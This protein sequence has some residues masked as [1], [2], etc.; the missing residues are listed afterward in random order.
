MESIWRQTCGIRSRPGLDQNIETDA[1]VIG[2]GMAGILI[3]DALKTA[4]R[5]VVVLEA[6]RIAGGQTQNTTAKITAQHG[7][8]Y[9]KLIRSFGE[10]RAKQYAQANQEAVSAYRA[11]IGTRRIDCDFEARDAFLYGDDLP[12]L[13]AE[14]EAAARLGL[15][16]DL[17]GG[18]GLPF[19]CAGAVRFRDQAQFHPLKFLRAL[20]DGLTVYEH[21]PVKVVGGNILKAG[22]H[23]VRA[24]HVVFAC[25][26][27][28]VNFPGLY[29]ARMYQERSYVLALENAPLAD[30]MFLGAD[31]GGYSLRWWNGLLLFGG[32]SRRAGE[33][34]DGGRYDALRRKAV[35]LFPGCR[36]TARWS[37][38]DCIPADGVPY[39]GL[40]A[41]SR[42]NWYVATGF[43][44]WGMT[45][46]MVS[47]QIITDLICGRRNPYAAVFSPARFGGTAAGGVLS[48]VGHSVKGLSRLFLQVPAAAAEKLLPGHGGIVFLNGKKVGVYREPGGDIHMVDPR[49]PHLGC[50]VEWDPD[51]LSWD[52]P[53]HGSRF[54]YTGKLISGPA[55]T[56][57]RG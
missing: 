46:S 55:Q 1:A 43:Q 12:A 37:A 24:N 16:A 6:D 13:S 17:T 41:S 45:S 5:Q 23:T 35:E 34:S 38:Q 40:Y 31:G 26:Y 28:F 51:E 11:L 32:E 18:A 14:A 20:A 10:Q 8:I 7:M 3:A 39:I 19:P 30:G 33:N 47:A 25:H 27:P 52:C 22:G 21:T 48:E 42:P 53:C 50:Q 15:P 36:E 29:F 57:L 4:G 56:D 44:K 49:C 54:D 2:G 9:G